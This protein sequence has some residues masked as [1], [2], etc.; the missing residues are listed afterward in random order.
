MGLNKVIIKDGSD[1]SPGSRLPLNISRTAG[2]AIKMAIYLGLEYI[3][4][5]DGLGLLAY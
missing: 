3:S 5:G 2:S 4:G 1:Y